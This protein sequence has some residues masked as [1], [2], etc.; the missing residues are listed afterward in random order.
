MNIHLRA[1]CLSALLLGRT[2]QAQSLVPAGDMVDFATIKSLASERAQ[3]PYVSRREDWPPFWSELGQHDHK[4]IKFR[5]E[6]GLWAGDNR[7]YV[8]EYIHPGGTYH[9]TALLGEIVKG[10][11]LDINWDSALF[12]YDDLSVPDSLSAPPGFSGF[13]VLLPVEKPDVL[14]EWAVF[15]AAN[16]FRCIA[17]GLRFGLTARGWVINPAEPHGEEAP[18]WQ[19]FWLI[20]PTNNAKAMELLGLMDGPSACGA[21]RFRITPGRSTVMEVEA[22]ITLRQTVPMFGLAPLASMCWFSEM[23][24]PKPLDYRPEVHESDGLLI[25]QAEGN[26][27]WV[28]LDTSKSLRHAEF[29]MD[30]LLGFGLIQRDRLFAS[31][32]DLKNSYQLRPSAYVEPVGVWPAGKIHLYEQPTSDPHAQNVTVCWQPGASLKVG[33]PF[34]IGYRIHWLNEMSAPGICKV[35]GSRRTQTAFAAEEKRPDKVEFVIDFSQSAKVF[36]EPSQIVLTAE[37]S[38]SAKLINKRLEPNPE[39]GGWRAFVEVQVAPDADSFTSNCRL[40]GEGRAISERWTYQ[41]KR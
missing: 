16:A 24:Q 8:V 4:K 31:Y 28:P 1:T 23:T 20:Q 39:T 37:V 5:R 26:V 6:Q 18:V 33:Q 15:D 35:L 10:V 9:E 41:W 27:I 14:D 38:D 21:Y 13:K 19:Q 34:P 30:S 11:A 36:S 7:P 32:Q 25:N 2:A 29:P 22:E 17:P 40:L 12:D 3:R